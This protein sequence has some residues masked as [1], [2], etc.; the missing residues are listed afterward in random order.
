MRRFENFMGFFELSDEELKMI[1][2]DL[3]A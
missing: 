3:K 1:D 2:K